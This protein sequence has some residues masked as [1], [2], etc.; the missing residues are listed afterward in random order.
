MINSIGDINNVKSIYIF[1]KIFNYILYD[2]TLKII[3]YH[4]KSQKKLDINRD[5]YKEYSKRFLPIEIEII[6]IKGSSGKFFNVD[7]IKDLSYFH[8][9]FDKDSKDKKR[10]YIKKNEKVS[11]IKL[12]I[13]YKIISFK[14]LFIDCKCI[15]SIYFIKFYRNNIDNMEKMFYGC[16]SLK[17]I[18]ISN[19][20]TDTVTN[21]RGMFSGCELLEELN[22]SNFNTKNVKTM[23]YMFNGCKSL[24]KLDLS[25]FNTNNVTDME[26]MFGRCDSLKELNLVNFNFNNVICMKKMFYFCHFKELIIPI[27]NLFSNKASR[28]LLLYNFP[29]KLRDEIM[30]QIRKDNILDGKDISDFEKEY[31]NLKK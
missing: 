28:D 10:C 29:E 4:K 2:R 26:S 7:N 13:D 23:G 27:S 14:F 3:K 19:F 6:P 15:E 5:N 8:V 30:N 9:F 18:N 12:I 17:R 20:N 1:K 22:L 16:S 25:N 11:K 24:K 21:M 31:A